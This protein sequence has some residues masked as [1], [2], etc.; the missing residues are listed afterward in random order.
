M[1]LPRAR[2][3]DRALTS[4]YQDLPE[5]REFHDRYRTLTQAA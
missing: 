3:L 4:H 5:A 2:R 1:E